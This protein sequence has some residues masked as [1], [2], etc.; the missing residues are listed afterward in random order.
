MGS[1]RSDNL[2]AVTQPARARDRV[3][4]QPWVTLKPES[5]PLDHVASL[6]SLPSNLDGRGGTKDLMGELVETHQDLSSPL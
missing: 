2:P 4:N 5:L 6:G 1:E 3:G